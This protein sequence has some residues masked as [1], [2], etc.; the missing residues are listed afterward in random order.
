MLAPIGFVDFGSLIFSL[1]LTF[2][3][4]NYHHHFNSLVKLPGSKI[5]INRSI[6]YILINIFGGIVAEFS[7]LIEMLNLETKLYIYSDTKRG[8]LK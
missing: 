1:W 4:Q 2:V 5:K 6:V 3:P 8:K 7:I